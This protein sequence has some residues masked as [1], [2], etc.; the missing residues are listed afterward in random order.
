MRSSLAFI[1]TL[2]INISFIS[3]QNNSPIIKHQEF[4]ACRTI[5]RDHTTI[6]RLSKTT[7]STTAFGN[8]S[9]VGKIAVSIFFVQSNGSMDQKRYEWTTMDEDSVIAGAMRAMD[10]WIQRGAL[11]GKNISF[12]YNVIRH[13]NPV[14]Q[15]P[16]EPIL[17]SSEDCGLS[18]SAIMHN[19]GFT[20]G[21]VTDQVNRFDDS[22]RTKCGADWAVSTFVV[23]NPSGAPA[24]FTDGSMN[25]A[26]WGGP[27]CVILFSSSFGGG[28]GGTFAHEFGHLFWARDEYDGSD[29]DKLPRAFGPRPNLANGNMQDYSTPVVPCIMNG[30]VDHLCSY[31]A[32]HVGW[33]ISPHF[34]TFTTDPAG[35]DLSFLEKMWSAPLSLP[36]AYGENISIA[37]ARRI[38]IDGVIHR[39]DHWQDGDTAVVKSFTN[40]TSSRSS[41]SG[42]YVN[43][44]EIFPY[45]VHRSGTNGPTSNT[46]RQIAEAPDGS[47]WVVG[48]GGA[49]RLK[50]RTWEQFTQQSGFPTSY[51]WSIALAPDSSVWA[52]G[53]MMPLMR[54]K[55]NTWQPMSGVPLNGVGVTSITFDHEGNPWIV[56]LSEGVARYR[57]GRWDFWD[58][59][60]SFPEREVRYIVCDNQNR[61]WVSAGFD[62]RIAAVSCWKDSA[63][64]HFTSIDGQPLIVYA[65]ELMLDPAGTVWFNA[66][67][68][69]QGFQQD[70]VF[71]SDGETLR[72][73][74]DQEL[75]PWIDQ[76]IP[77]RFTPQQIDPRGH[78]WGRVNTSSGNRFARYD[79]YHYTF[80]DQYDDLLPSRDISCIF[81]GANGTG[82]FGFLGNG[83]AA[84][85][86]LVKRFITASCSSV[87]FGDGFLGSSKTVVMVLKNITDRQQQIKR[88]FLDSS[89]TTT[90]LTPGNV[91]MP[92][93]SLSF[94]VT[95]NP[96]ISGQFSSVFVVQSD[97]D[98]AR[99]S[100]SGRRSPAAGA[101]PTVTLVLPFDGA[102]DIEYNTTL[103]WNSA[104][105]ATKYRLQVSLTPVFST[106]V[107]NDSTITDTSKTI[108]PLQNN[109]TYYWRV[110]PSNAAGTGPASNIRRFTTMTVIPQIPLLAAPADSARNLPLS[111]ALT[112]N[113]VAGAASYRLQMSTSSNFSILILDDST[114]TTPSR[115][116][117]QLL[118]NATYY[119][120]VCAKNDGGTSLWS[121]VRN[122]STIVTA[123]QA[124]SLAAPADS[125]SNVEPTTTLRWN[126]AAGALSYHLQLAT[127]LDFTSTVV[128]DSVLTKTSRAVGPLSF[129]TTYYWQVRA[130]NEGGY[131]VFSQVRQFSTIR[132]T[133]T[134]QLDIG[135]P[136]E[137]TLK[138]NYPNPFNPSTT[139]R[140][141]LPTRS[142]VRLVIY[143]VLGQ[144][145]D[146]LVDAEQE[147]GYKSA[148]WNAIVTSG[149]YF[150]RLEAVSTDN[151]AR[152]FVETKKMLLLR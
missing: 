107:M 93:D 127:S 48:P 56:L 23:Y 94:T 74:Q 108:G 37:F 17:R 59:K 67:V 77:A 134:E 78:W 119:W 39:F 101:P 118:N 83:F 91:L 100:L 106:T 44:G 50:E 4:Q 89:C 1:I 133:S 95:F 5:F 60:T 146:E 33:I 87:D 124:P 7:N 27:Y 126:E 115:Q 137:F 18:I 86:S 84:R 147:A 63:W 125:S 71:R 73:A 51:G 75:P 142:S 130:K 128:N 34:T 72:K 140:Y 30:H 42:S 55:G 120:R 52:G 70:Y 113:V 43:T 3:A 25:F 102:R 123:P 111:I 10:L 136:E 28:I 112:W 145:I 38:L 79:G 82:Y 104:S 148:V 98:Y 150:Y 49:A 31:T 129:A 85:E 32:A 2:L 141:G 76:N 19:A 149:L 117:E 131:S 45:Q 66:A 103:R 61:I 121:S 20:E 139:L 143:N 64:T 36:Y 151:P 81:F 22:I 11:Y 57:D 21:T 35:P 16:Y 90:S 109:T 135:I 122:F 13:D 96:A 58:S 12:V 41:W 114:L 92:Q 14:T 69:E 144:I 8:D 24:R 97:S 65:P 80:Y 9:L 105:G 88:I 29:E 6:S 54:F 40:S 26:M 68:R 132:T 46:I 138:Q 99:L 47:V 15:Q 152:R 53:F 116:V 110:I 62:Q